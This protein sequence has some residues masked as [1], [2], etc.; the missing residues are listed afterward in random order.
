M[1][2]ARESAK[3]AVDNTKMLIVVVNYNGLLDTRRCLESIASIDDSTVSTLVVDNGSTED[4][5]ERLRAEFPWCRVERLP[6]NTGWAGGNNVGLRIGVE[7]IGAEHV[8]L[9]N[10]DTTVAPQIV[11]RL[12]A[13]GRSAP[14][15]GIIG[16]VI[17]FME[18]PGV[19]M[20]D[21]CLFN[22][23]DSPGFFVRK[24][25]P[26]EAA[27]PPR[28]AEVDIV[29]GCAMMVSARVVREIGPIDER[30]FLIHE[31]SDFCLRARRAG[32]KC[33]VLAEALVWH[34]GSSSFKRVGSQ[35]QRY[36]D[37]RNLFLLLRKHLGT[38]DGTRGAGAS[39]IEYARYAYHRFCIEREH[40]QVES[41]DAVIDGLC[42]AMAGRW[43][44]HHPRRRP[45]A[46]P[47]HLA[48]EAA[49]RLRSRP[50]GVAGAV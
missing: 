12:A 43:G 40:D 6:S 27:D 47:I 22:H 48:F 2:Q 34:K 3:M 50:T 7:E 32:F 9:L 24:V 36:Y 31:E 29:N 1:L 21:G 45:A 5:S 17:C 28:L 15:F 30:F 8:L 49:R 44:G 39:W 33:G 35:V 4:P 10:N 37:T 38:A 14:E 23:P 20:T 46:K 16:P 42:D 18:E 11:A 26:I 41:A 25:V 13:A 19:V